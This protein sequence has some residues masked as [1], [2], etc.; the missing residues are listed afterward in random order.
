[1]VDHGKGHLTHD[2][3][4]LLPGWHQAE[5]F[6]FYWKTIQIPSRKKK[7]LIYLGENVTGRNRF[8]LYKEKMF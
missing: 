4:G 7:P 8:S 3:G 6:C 5:Y 2:L 1:M